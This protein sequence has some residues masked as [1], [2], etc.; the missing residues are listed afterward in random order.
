M[1]GLLSAIGSPSASAVSVAVSNCS[2]S[3]PGSLRQ[4]VVDAGN[5][6]SVTFSVPCA[7]IDD[8]TGMI[9][10]NHDLTITGPGASALAISGDSVTG[11]FSIAAGAK[12]TI[13]DLTLENGMGLNGGA[14]S[15]NGQLTTRNV[16]FSANVATSAGGAVYSTGKVSSSNDTY[17][18]NTANGG[19]GGAIY[20][21]GSMTTANDTFTSNAASTDGGAIGATAPVAS[22]GDAFSANTANNNGGAVYATSTLSMANDSVA[23]NSTSN[24]YG[25]GIYATGPSTFSSDRITGNTAVVPP[26]NGAEA[27]GIY[28]SGTASLTGST[29][30]GNTAGGTTAGAACYSSG[31]YGGGIFNQGNL[32]VTASTVSANTSR[33]QPGYCGYW[34]QAAGAGIYNGG[35]L[36]LTNSTLAA[37]VDTNS[38]S[39]ASLN[40]SAVYNQGSATITSSTFAYNTGGG[41][42]YNVNNASTVHLAADLLA[43]NTGGSCSGNGITDD[44]YSVDSDGTCG[45]TGTS[46]SGYSTMGLL[47]GSLADNG[48]PTKTVSLLAANPAIGLVTDP[49]KCPATDQRGIVR[50][51]PCDAGSFDTAGLGLQQITFT[52]AATAQQVGGSYTVTATGGSSGNPVVFTIDASATSVCSIAGSV[53][54]FQAVG[55]CT[56]DANQAGSPTFSAAP[57]VKLS[58]AVGQSITVTTCANSGPGSL[59]QAVVDAGNGGSVTFSVPCATIDDPTGMI[60][61]NHDLTITG[62]GASALAISGDSVTGIFS[63]AAG[64]KVTIS[65]LTLEN[66]MGLNGGAIS[67]N[68]QLTTRNVRFSANVATSAGGAVYSTGKVSS[69]NDTYAGNTANGGRGGAIYSTGSMTTA[70]D[71]FTSNAASTD[72]GA[73]GATAPV[74]SSGDAFSANTANNNGG[75]V[76]AT[77]TLSMANDS[78]AGNSTSNGYGGGIYATG[79]STFSSDRITGNTAVVPPGNGAE[80]GGIYTSGTASL[81]GSTV[82]GNT[83]GGTTAGAACY[84]SG[85]YGG[86]IFNQGNL[87]VTASTVSAN[88]SRSQ[89]G[90]C[91]YWPQAAGAGIYNGGSLTLTNSTLAAN[92]DTNSSSWASLNGS[93]VYN[94]G[95]AT[96]TSST[97]AYNTGGGS[98]YNVNNASTVHLA[99]DLLASNTGGSCS[100]NGITDDGYSVDSDGTC[101]L[102]GTSVSGYSTMGLLIG[103][104]ADNG[105]PTKTVSLLAANPAI[106]LVTDPT[107]CPATDQRGIVRGAPCDAGSFDTAGLGLQQITFT[108][109]ATAQQVGGSYTV[110]ATGGSSGNP[111]VFTIDASATSVCSIA[112][113]VVSFQA[114]G[115]CTIDANQAGNA[116][117]RASDQA[118]LTLSVGKGS[119]VI[120]FTSSPPSPAYVGGDAYDVAV[121]GGGSGNPVLLSIP[122]TSQTTCSLSNGTVSFLAVGVC[123]IDASQAGN[124]VYQPAVMVSQMI[125]VLKTNLTITTTALP[126]ATRGGSYSFKLEANYGFSPYKWKLV[127]G[128][129]VLPKGL[130]L[131]PNTGV[132]SG[133]PSKTSSTSTFIIEV[134]DTPPGGGKFR[135]TATCQLTLSIS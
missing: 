134:L 54:S 128:S 113:S 24:G 85:A 38:S 131:S 133:K 90:Y 125:V 53:V 118:Q 84:S 120:S 78:V 70:N 61:I 31:A 107:K 88:T 8:P 93:A 122:S 67:S 60:L 47:I 63:I 81:T 115:T 101:G 28:T 98:L 66:G 100:G 130:K 21:T 62:P 20:S 89:P 41:S 132:I 34:P 95:S 37:N 52:S 33:S 102:T 79:P 92:V 9:L 4:A 126:T 86:G 11:I 19:R 36:T 32:T 18:G 99:A 10:I 39:W 25:G 76:Y 82:S 22:S 43:S 105:G 42:L 109:A 40:G 26:G 56:I 83:A 30:S 111:V 29:V 72:G 129:G 35:S 16:R 97:F 3:G 23:G 45:L 49:T 121:V 110:T 44:G 2:N 94:Q 50:G 106:G 91:G 15:S 96:I 73:I 114:V 5:G 80:A 58:I 13:S 1:S 74:A 112:G 48:G 77:S 135:E 127:K 104:L 116:Q 7:T 75:A 108:S 27:G 51:A 119:Q 68:G 12:V 123:V 14:I 87:T 17:A 6:G 46:V 103:S 59:R 64:A 65:D 57:Q 55:T 71:T 117:F 124:S 69:S